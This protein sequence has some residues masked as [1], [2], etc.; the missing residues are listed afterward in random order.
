MSSAFAVSITPSI[1][2][3]ASGASASAIAV[4][5]KPS[6]QRG[7]NAIKAG[8]CDELGGD[9]ARRRGPRIR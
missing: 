8:Q 4:C 3:C 9:V 7:G 1:R 5:A 6:D 2:A